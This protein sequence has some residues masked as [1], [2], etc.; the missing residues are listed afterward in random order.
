M[1]NFRDIHKELFEGATM[2]IGHIHKY[3][4]TA[5]NICIKRNYKSINIYRWWIKDNEKNID[6]LEEKT[7]N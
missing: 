4:V 5:E 3:L 1:L 7:R 2:F 6:E